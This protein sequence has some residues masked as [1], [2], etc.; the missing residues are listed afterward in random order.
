MRRMNL[1]TTA[2]NRTTCGLH[3]LMVDVLLDPFLLRERF[4]GDTVMSI[5]VFGAVNP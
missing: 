4:I 5:D 3:N 2:T 1:A